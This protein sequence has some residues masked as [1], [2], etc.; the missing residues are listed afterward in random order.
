MHGLQG[1]LG[2]EHLVRPSVIQVL[3][4]EVDLV[5]TVV[6]V[7]YDKAVSQ[8]VQVVEPVAPLRL[9]FM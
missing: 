7:G 2:T 5:G 9:A 3:N 6:A 8:G 4:D 1:P